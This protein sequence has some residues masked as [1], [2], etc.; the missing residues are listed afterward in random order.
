MRSK[1]EMEKDAISIFWKFLIVF[2]ML[3]IIALALKDIFS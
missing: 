3:M 2:N 1:E